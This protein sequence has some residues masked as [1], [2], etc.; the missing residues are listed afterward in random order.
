M[1]KLSVKQI[2]YFTFAVVGLSAAAAF[3]MQLN[4]GLGPWD[5][6]GRSISYVTNMKV[7]DVAIM[8][9]VSCVVLQLVILRKA[10]KIYNVL[11]LLVGYVNGK[12]INVFY[13]GIFEEMVL[14]NY[15]VTLGLF[16]LSVAII[17]FF[18]SMIQTAEVVNLP[19]E[20]LCDA[21]ADQGISKFSVIRQ[22]I[23]V[24]CVISI[25]IIT[26]VFS[27][28]LT[29][30]EGTIISMVLFGPLMGYFI[31]HLKHFTTKYK[32]VN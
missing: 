30:R 31:P 22:A 28:P 27:V 23:D 8:M 25:I 15:F 32:I 26:F 21:I 16:L 17:A 3:Q 9:S 24:L 20:G 4:I 10:F 13:Y 6:L 14:N 29:L 1:K 2:L 19:L 7:G 11:S 18:V 5:G 12:I